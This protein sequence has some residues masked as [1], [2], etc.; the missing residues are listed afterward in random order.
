MSNHCSVWGGL[1]QAEE[2]FFLWTLSGWSQEVKSNM[3]DFVFLCCLSWCSKQV[4]AT[5]Y[6]QV[7]YLSEGKLW[8][9]SYAAQEMEFTIFKS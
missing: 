6:L 1:K 9:L 8:F 4:S 2:V 7:F 5:G 3:L